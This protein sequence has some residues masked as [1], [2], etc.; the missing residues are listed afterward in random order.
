M[1]VYSDR[2]VDLESPGVFCAGPAEGSS[3]TYGLGVTAR[4]GLAFWMP[5]AT[6]RSP[7]LSPSVTIRY[8][9]ICSP[10]CTGRTSTMLSGPTTTT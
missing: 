6:T 8:W 2:P 10:T 4:P 5:S 1:A 7:G 3:V 9:P